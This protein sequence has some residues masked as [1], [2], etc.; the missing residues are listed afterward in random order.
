MKTLNRVMLLGSVG[1]DP[2]VKTTGGGTMVANFSLA[3]S[4]RFKGSD[5]NWQESTDWHNI[6]VFGKTA[7]V[8]RDYVH[9]GD[10]IHI[11]GRIQTRS[12]DDKEGKKQYRT[13]IV[14]DSL[15]LLGGKKERPSAKE[16]GFPQE[17]AVS[18]DDIPF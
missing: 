4:N 13:E 6:V 14:C 7:E 2:E 18:D 3:T 8:V 12:W 16:M 1:K 10:P 17:P 15:I 5:G 11:E 9:K